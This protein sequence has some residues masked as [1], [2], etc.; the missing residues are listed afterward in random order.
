ML[1]WLWQK[2][3]ACISLLPHGESGWKPARNA[4]KNP[5]HSLYNMYNMEIACMFQESRD[6]IGK[7]FGSGSQ[8]LHI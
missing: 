3:K 6:V 2:R 4:G 8:V 1:C 7:A 5:K